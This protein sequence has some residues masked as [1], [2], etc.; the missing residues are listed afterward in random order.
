MYGSVCFKCGGAGAVLSKRGRAAQNFLNELRKIPASE[1]KV[2]DVIYALGVPGFMSDRWV[3][4][5]SIEPAE[6]MGKAQLRINSV[7]HKNPEQKQW[8]ESLQCGPEYMIRKAMSAEE[9]KAAIAK[10]LEFQAS[11]N[12][13]G[14]PLKKVLQSA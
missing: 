8:G 4:V 2:G 7:Y 11:L 3:R 14:K 6:N 12:K 13:M 1:V 5:E 9:R 10:A